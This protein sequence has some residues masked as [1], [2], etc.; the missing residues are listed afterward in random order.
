MHFKEKKI[1][2][3]SIHDCHLVS[4][5]LIPERIKTYQTNAYIVGNAARDSL[6]G[7]LTNSL[8]VFEAQPKKVKN[9]A[10]KADRA[11]ICALHKNWDKTRISFPPGIGLSL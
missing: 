3:A 7:R 4:P 1:N 8:L 5:C 10:N 6:Y 11:R 2:L 9:K